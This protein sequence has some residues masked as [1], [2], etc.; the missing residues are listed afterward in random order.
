MAVPIKPD[1]ATGGLYV[2]ALAM[3]PAIALG[4]GRF[5]YALVL[6]A[7]AATLGLTWAQAGWLNGA[8]AAG[9][10][11]GALAASAAM[12]RL[13]GPAVVGL[14]V[15][16]SVAGMAGCALTADFTLLFAL[17][18]LTGAGGA[19]A[20][21][22][23]G[24][25]AASAAQGARGGLLLGLFYAGPGF[26]I[27]ASGIAAPL[28]FAGGGGWQGAW[29]MLAALSAV[30]ALPLAWSLAGRHRTRGGPAAAPAPVPLLAMTPILLAYATFGFGYIGY[31]TFVFAWV[32]EAWGAGAGQAGFWVLI[33]TAGMAAPWLW[34]G[35]LDR[36]LPARAFSVLTALCGVAAALPL[37][38]EGAIPMLASAAIF[39]ASFFAVV[40]STTQFVRRNMAPEGWARGVA[41]MTVSFS[42]GQ[43]TGPVLAGA[44]ADAAGGL[45]AA[46]ALSAGGLMAAALLALAQ[47][48][49]QSA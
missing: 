46:L 7:M 5:A 1:P 40:A 44:M 32:R 16:V 30:M 22:A 25:L 31:M 42:L 38:G 47:R 27:A 49:L 8:N 20:F 12:V 33:G 15:A 18:L 21:V 48:P 19:L 6:P 29:L 39:G 37:M 11:L 9:Y 41:A 26:G 13:G 34:A 14:G 35:L 4:L 24:V 45:A 43:T 28:W 10:M 36:L 23:G 17:R 2:A 3:A